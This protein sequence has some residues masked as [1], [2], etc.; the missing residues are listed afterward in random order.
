MAE[1][2]KPMV[3]TIKVSN[4][5]WSIE[6]LCVSTALC[7]R[8]LITGCTQRTLEVLNQRN[9]CNQD[10]LIFLVYLDFAERFHSSSVCTCSTI[11]GTLSDANYPGDLGKNENSRS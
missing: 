11:G 4:K 8:F 6:R 5:L 10:S 7:N 1:L 9:Y 2:G 3:L